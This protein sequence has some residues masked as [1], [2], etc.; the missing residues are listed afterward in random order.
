MSPED[1]SPESDVQ[2]LLP[3]LTFRTGGITAGLHQDNFDVVDEEPKFRN[4]EEYIRFMDSF[5]SV[6]EGSYR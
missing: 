4:K 5:S 6:E 1:R 3:V 2:H